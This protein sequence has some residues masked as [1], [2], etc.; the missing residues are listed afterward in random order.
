MHPIE[1]LPLELLST[2]FINSLPPV[3]CHNLRSSHVTT[4]FTIHYIGLVCRTW[5]DMTIR[6][7]ELWTDITIEDLSIFER[8]Q[9]WLNRAVDR[10]LHIAIFIDDGGPYEEMERCLELV[11][12]KGDQW[13]TLAVTGRPIYGEDIETFL[14]KSL[15]NLAEVSITNWLDTVDF[16][17]FNSAPKLQRVTLGGSGSGM[18]YFQS[19]PLVNHCAVS[20]LDED[21]EWRGFITVLANKSPL[22]STLE[23]LATTFEKYDADPEPGATVPPWPPLGHLKKLVFDGCHRQTI[24]YVLAHINAPALEI[25]QFS[26]LG[27]CHELRAP[28][29]IPI[30]KTIIIN[31]SRFCT[32]RRFLSKVA[33]VKDVV[34]KVDLVDALKHVEVG[35][36]SWERHAF[37]LPEIETFDDMMDHFAWFATHTKVEWTLPGDV[38]VDGS[39]PNVLMLVYTVFTAY[40]DKIFTKVL[41]EISLTYTMTSVYF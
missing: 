11:C 3:D 12:S 40:A 21:S 15:P 35:T 33:N 6:T 31:Q 27:Y 1:S 34:I 37:D 18:F 41:G 16:T 19:A 14:P 29:A 30:N 24:T 7:P 28:I 25:V 32:V 10:P 22:I 26:N 20:E 4:R 36:K 2:I 13:S 9:L 17:P 39:A 38:A 23:I 8:T 5:R